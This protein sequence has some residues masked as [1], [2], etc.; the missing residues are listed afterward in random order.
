MGRQRDHQNVTELANPPGVMPIEFK[1]DFLGL[2][3]E[4]GTVA[5]GA[6]KVDVF[7]V[8]DIAGLYDGEMDR[9]EDAIGNLLGE[10]RQVYIQVLD[11]AFIDCF[12]HRLFNLIG[13][14]KADRVGG[15]HI[16]I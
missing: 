15:S 3:Q 8:C 2:M 11:L 14:T 10:L 1:N 9:T 6:R 16:M 5:Y 4:C 7:V 13:R 12:S